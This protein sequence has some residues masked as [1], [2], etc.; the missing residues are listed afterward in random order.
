MSFSYDI[1]QT[2]YEIYRYYNICHK[3]TKHL[4]NLMTYIVITINLIENN[5]REK[6]NFGGKPFWAN[7]IYRNYNIS[8]NFTKYLIITILVIKFT[9]YLIKIMRYNVKQYFS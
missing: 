9:I 5:W 4:T 8:N 1:S 3:K 2:K 6:E 7:E